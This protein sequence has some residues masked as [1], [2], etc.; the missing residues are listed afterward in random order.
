MAFQDVCSWNSP[1]RILEWV[2]TSFSRGSSQPRYR[3]CVS[4]ISC[5]GRQILYH[6]ITWKVQNRGLVQFSCSVVSDSLWPRGLQHARLP[7]PSPTPRVYS[8]S[9]LLSWWCH[10]TISSSAIPFSSWLQSFP[11]SGSF[12]VSQLFTSDGQV[13][14]FQFQHQSFQWIFTTD[15]FQDRLVG[16]PRTVYQRADRIESTDINSL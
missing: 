3:T 2:A 9:C 16:S 1:E 10:P 5:L 6:C 11:A 14:E 13:L 8:N 15:F 7:C 4:Y 12:Q